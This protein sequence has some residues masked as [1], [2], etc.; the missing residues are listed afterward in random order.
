MY[1][2]ILLAK[3]QRNYENNIIS[4]YDKQKKEFLKQ[5]DQA[6]KEST[7]Q[8]SDQILQLI[9]NPD[10]SETNIQVENIVQE[11][12]GEYYSQLTKNGQADKKSIKEKIKGEK[13]LRTKQGRRNFRNALGQ[14]YKI[15]DYKIDQIMWKHLNTIYQGVQGSGIDLLP[16]VNRLRGFVKQ[17]LYSKTVQNKDLD[18]HRIRGQ[19]IAAAG[20]LREGLFFE[21]LDKFFE[22]NFNDVQI[23]QVGGKNEETDI[24]INFPTS[25]SVQAQTLIDSFSVQIKSFEPK[26][27]PNNSYK[28]AYSIK[29]NASLAAQLTPAFWEEIVYKISN[30]L[31]L[32]KS[33]F[34]DHVLW[35]TRSG[36]IWSVDLIQQFKQHNYYLGLT[37]TKKTAWQTP[38][39]ADNFIVK[40]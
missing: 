28:Y 37:Q 26:N 9:S 29:Y 23:I 32:F 14:Y 38:E 27:I 10:Y 34:G 30:D 13:D 21:G 12:I 6:K 33:A 5:L 2:S 4:Y 16:L 31:N 17:Q 8:I 22:Q 35:G 25:M 40:K 19:I 36:L 7:F 39:Q 11:L 1:S 24:Q 15:S 20:F 3:A 18:L